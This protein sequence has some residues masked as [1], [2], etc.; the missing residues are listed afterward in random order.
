MTYSWRE[1]CPVNLDQ[2][3]LLTV[4]HWGFDQTVHRG[5]MIIHSDQAAKVLQALKRLFESGFPIE[6]MRLVDEYQADDDLSIAA[7][8]TSAFN[9]REVAGK[10]GVWSQH[11]YGRA[12]DIN[13]IQNPYVS[14]NGKVSPPSA[15]A[16]KDR[17]KKEPG[18]ILAGDST[19]KAF[20]SIGW[21][22]GGYWSSVKDYQ[23]FSSNGR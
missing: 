4:D 7:N 21:R 18:M 23:H 3:R 9:C 16:Y 17:S 12:I 1:G 5:E 15:A 13:P 22:W 2:L 10:P 20:A 8:N 14:G 6:K 19:V 11:A